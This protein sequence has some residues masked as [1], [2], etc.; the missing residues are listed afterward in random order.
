MSANDD[1]I[2]VINRTALIDYLL[3]QAIEKYCSPQRGV[4]LILECDFRQFD[5]ANGS[6]DQGRDGNCTGNKLQAE[7]QLA[8]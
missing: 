3:N 8:T 7:G 6:K 4:S 1:V 2:H 5:Y